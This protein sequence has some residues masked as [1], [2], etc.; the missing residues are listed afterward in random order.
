MICG[1]PPFYA[2]KISELY[3]NITQT[4]LMFPGYFSESL[5][6]LLKNLL[7]RDPKKRIGVYD[8]KEIM[9]HEFFK[10][11]NWESLAKKD[12]QPPLDLVKNKRNCGSIE[13]NEEEDKKDTMKLITPLIEDEAKEQGGQIISENNHIKGFSFVRPKETEAKEEEEKNPE[14]K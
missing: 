6:N 7:C 10:G 3:S 1:T 13:S 2:E 9:K 4:N 5:K 14:N 8:K 11:I 12:I